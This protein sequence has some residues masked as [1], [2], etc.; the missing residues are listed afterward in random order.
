M[1]KLTGAKKAAF[2]ERMAK[3]R[4][5]AKRKS[6]K[7]H[8]AGRPK[9]AAAKKKNG[10]KK[11]NGK[12]TGAKK[13][14]FL[15][16]MAKGRRKAAKN[17]KRKKNAGK[18]SVRKTKKAIGGQSFH[19]KFPSGG[20]QAQHFKRTAKA[21]KQRK[22]KRKR[23]DG[24]ADASAMYETFHGRAPRHLIDYEQYVKYPEHFAELGRLLELKVFLDS[25]NPKFPFT[26]FG[27]CKVV[28][29]P[30]GSNI[31]FIGG[32]QSINLDSLGIETDKDMIELGPCVYIAYRTTKGFHDF[33]PTSYE[34][35][36]GEEDGVFPRLGYDRLN[37]TL[38][39][40]GGNYDVKRPGIVN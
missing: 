1:A 34:H 29:T 18:G 33:E 10:G 5:K 12:L 24:D 11:K 40:I 3:G 36:F 23:N 35:K 28:C 25:A 7:K 39:L 32:D 19:Y 21:T 20:S 38:F 13:A 17:P 31:Y 15:K 8:A 16:R 30:D 26:S 22:A 2:L 6:P 27:D 37:R 4:R 14:E 9:R